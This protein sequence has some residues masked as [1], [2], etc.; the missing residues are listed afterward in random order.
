MQLH[1]A[2]LS[3]SGISNEFIYFPRACRVTF[4]RPGRNQ[5]RAHAKTRHCRKNIYRVQKQYRL[6]PVFAIK[7]TFQE[8]IYDLFAF[9][10]FLFLLFLFASRAALRSSRRRRRPRCGVAA[11]ARVSI[12]TNEQKRFNFAPASYRRVNSA[13]KSLCPLSDVIAWRFYIFHDFLRR[14]GFGPVPVHIIVSRRFVG[15]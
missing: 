15:P 1:N 6:F 11:P 10:F 2:L 8:L 14:I 3:S 5:Y 4:A 12:F 9:F 13:M 7:R